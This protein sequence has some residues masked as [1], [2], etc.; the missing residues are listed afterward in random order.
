SISTAES[1]SQ[2]T[3]LSRELWPATIENARRGRRSVAPRGRSTAWLA[4]PSSGGAVTLIFHAVPCRPT[5]PG[6]RAP[7]TTRNSSLFEAFIPPV[8][9]RSFPPVE[10]A[11]AC[12][13]NPLEDR[14]LDG[15]LVL[16]GVMLRL[17]L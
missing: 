10:V 9:V 14:L 16:D 7:G 13:G 17:R 11:R 4:R 2:E 12:A 3:T 15:I 1:P 8:Y 6:R 5:T